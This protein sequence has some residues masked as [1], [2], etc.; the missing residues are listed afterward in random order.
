MY[1]NVSQLLREHSGSSRAFELDEERATVYDADV[2]RFTGT[3]SLVRTDRGVWVSAVLESEIVCSCSLCLVD[4]RQPLHMTIEEEFFPSV[5]PEGGA[6]LFGLADD[7]ESFS[8]DQNH[9]LDLTE[10]VRQYS[11][12]N[13]PMKP[14]CRDDCKGLC[15][16]CASNL[17][18]SRCE[19]DQSARDGRW[20]PLL[21]LVPSEG[22][23]KKGT[24]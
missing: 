11:A 24:S 14:V 7:G 22:T 23:A 10:A 21:D 12:L 3:V 13:V 6:M 20:R 18:V 1:F 9:I 4:C 17:N 15:P 5:D 8:I 2:Q 19:C 16:N